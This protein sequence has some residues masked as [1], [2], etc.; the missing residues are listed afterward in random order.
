MARHRSLA[1]EATASVEETVMT[2]AGV[3]PETEAAS[4]A[5]GSSKNAAKNKKKKELAKRCAC[6]ERA[7]HES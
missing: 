5:G 1:V 3:T 4:G 2:E 6:R 7:S